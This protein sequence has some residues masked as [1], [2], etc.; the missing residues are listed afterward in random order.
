MSNSLI[1]PSFLPANVRGDGRFGPADGDEP[2]APTL[3]G[4]APARESG[5]AKPPICRLGMPFN[6]VVSVIFRGIPRERSGTVGAGFFFK[7]FWASV[8]FCSNSARRAADLGFLFNVKC[9]MG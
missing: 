1:P 7:L 6:G 4:V 2:K 8:D 5:E 3:V 9:L